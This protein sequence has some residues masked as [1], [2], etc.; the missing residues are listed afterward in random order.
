MVDIEDITDCVGIHLRPMD[1]DFRNLTA[2]SDLSRFM[3]LPRSHQKL[4]NITVRVFLKQ[5]ANASKLVVAY[6]P[7][8]TQG[9]SLI[10]SL[11]ATTGNSLLSDISMVASCSTIIGSHSTVMLSIRRKS[12]G[13][14]IPIQSF[15]QHIN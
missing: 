10:S 1:N 3:F 5:W 6:P 13:N 4:C 7:T 2:D 12:K 9:R 11:N 14:F 8:W 15:C